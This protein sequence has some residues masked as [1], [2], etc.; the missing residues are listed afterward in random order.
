MAGIRTSLWNFVSDHMAALRRKQ[1]TQVLRRLADVEN[2]PSAI[3][4]GSKALEQRTG[5]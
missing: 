5:L 1:L 4:V 3:V 2:L